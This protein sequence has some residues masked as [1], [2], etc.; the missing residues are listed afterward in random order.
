MHISTCVYTMVYLIEVKY[1]G[2]WKQT[3]GFYS[4][5]EKTFT[6]QDNFICPVRVKLKSEPSSGRPI[7]Q[8][9]K[10]LKEVTM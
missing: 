3:S 6:N 4:L 8:V 10:S 9:L 2:S 5:T 7:V 1:E